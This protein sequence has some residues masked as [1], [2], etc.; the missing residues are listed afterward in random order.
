MNL[1]TEAS[2]A[3]LTTALD[4]IDSV[5][6]LV[7]PLLGE[8]VPLADAQNLAA[9]AVQG[10]RELAWVR[11]I[12][13][14]VLHSQITLPAHLHPY[15][16]ELDG[17]S[18][19]WLGLS[20]EIAQGELQAAQSGGLAG[21]GAATHAIG[22]WLQ[23]GR[24]AQELAQQLASL[25]NV[26]PLVSTPARYQRIA[27]RRVFDWLRHVVGDAPLAAE[28]G[29]IYRWV[30]LDALGQ[31]ACLERATATT[32]TFCAT[33]SIPMQP[34][35][36]RRFMQGRALHTTLARWLGQ[37]R[38][39]QAPLSRAITAECYER[40]ENAL[41]LAASAA[42]RWPARFKTPEDWSAWAALTLLHPALLENSD[43]QRLLELPGEYQELGGDVPQTMHTLCLS[44]VAEYRKN[45]S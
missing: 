42:M 1:L 40:T 4:P 17:L 41:A 34:V 28:F 21:T 35:E 13:P 20:L 36:W 24:P 19:V 16:V 11:P 32:E 45:L 27:D 8:P 25:S 3:D 33:S 23:S 37:L 39:K 15:L 5:Y 43:V 7:D 29:P 44:L 26:H 9:S 31:L 18:D 30:Y 10:A 38:I 22:G 2:L 6:L 14:V 12:I